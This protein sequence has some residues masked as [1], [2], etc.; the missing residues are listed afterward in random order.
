VH[1]YSPTGYW[2]TFTGEWQP[3]LAVGLTF[4]APFGNKVA[5]GR[6]LQASSSLKRS[7]I[8]RTDLDRVIRENIVE[9][10]RALGHAAQAIQTRRG[11]LD[12]YRQTLEA[13]QQQYQIGD[14]TLIDTLTTEEDLTREHIEL[15]S[16]LQVYYSLLARLRFEVARLIRFDNEGSQTEVV[17]FDP[18]GLVV[19]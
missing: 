18:A 17:T 19:R 16:D 5:K 3:Y 11:S 2:R 13:A 15:V 9:V 1:Y 4:D 7:E 6:A 8:E 10:R 14:L 12:L